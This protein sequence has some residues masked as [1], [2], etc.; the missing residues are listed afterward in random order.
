MMLIN[1]VKRYKT[2]IDVAAKR[3]SDGRCGMRGAGR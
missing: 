2:Q 3:S 1:L